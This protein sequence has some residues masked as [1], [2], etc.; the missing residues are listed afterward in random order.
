LTE[1]RD[2]EIL[3]SIPASKS[4]AHLNSL[5]FDL[6][7]E[8]LKILKRASFVDGFPV[9]EL[10][11]GSGRAGALI[12]R[13][14]FN[15]VACDLSEE[16]R[17]RHRL[18]VTRDYISST[19]YLTLDMESL[20]FCSDSIFNIASINTIHELDRPRK[21]LLE[22]IRVIHKSGKLLLTDF[23]YTGF[24][25]IALVHEASYGSPHPEG[26]LKID[27]IHEILLEYFEAVEIFETELNKTFYCTSKRSG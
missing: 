5:G 14:G 4:D 8:Y 7:S 1:I 11:A 20:P 21:S 2:R 23:N 15:L 12:T 19:E 25:I 13:L 9:L 24:E 3:S 18:R 16:S 10:A 6:T 22:M 26:S 17:D 27:R